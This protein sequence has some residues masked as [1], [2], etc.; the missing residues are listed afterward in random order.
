MKAFKW[1]LII[2]LLSTL[3]PMKL[4]SQDDLLAYVPGSI[5]RNY[6]NIIGN[7]NLNR[8]EF[9]MDF[10]LHQIFSVENSGLN[11]NQNTGLYEIPLPIKSFEASNQLLYH[12]F[13]MLLKA[14][15]HPKIIIGIGYNQ[16][17]QFLEGEN[18][19]V[20]NIKITL[21]G[22]TKEYPVSCIISSCSDNLVYING[23]KNIKLTDF[24][25]DPP[26]KFQ[27]LVKVENE[28]MINFG[29]VFLFINENQA[30]KN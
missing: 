18:Y 9:R 10:P 22:V 1:Y 16:L 5:C 19:T 29:F 26:E 24:N 20:Q 8:F 13:L 15:L 7:T 28:V 11:T 3:I 21:A 27:G 2:L 23:Y 6:I 25:I 4:F 12:D 30:L 17:L 14:D